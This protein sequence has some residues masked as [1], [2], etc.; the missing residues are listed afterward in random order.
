MDGVVKSI[1]DIIIFKLIFV[2]EIHR[3]AFFRCL[4]AEGRSS[5][6]RG[7]SKT[8]LICSL[9]AW[10]DLIWKCSLCDYRLKFIMLGPDLSVFHC[11]IYYLF[12][13]TSAIRQFGMQLLD[14]LLNNLPPWWTKMGF[15]PSFIS[16]IWLS[17]LVRLSKV[18][19]SS[20]LVRVASIFSHSLIF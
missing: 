2:L 4:L 17:S 19:Y 13:C 12:Y 7:C 18:F 9:L 3:T 14:F 16:E 1:K 10:L 6:D 8:F 15:V 5:W 11:W 20:V